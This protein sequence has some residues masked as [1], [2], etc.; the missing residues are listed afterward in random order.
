MLLFYRSLL[1]SSD[2]YFQ[3]HMDNFIENFDWYSIQQPVDLFPKFQSF[4]MF[5]LFDLFC[6]LKC[7][8]IIFAEKKTKERGF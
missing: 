3:I 5:F 7:S 6:V 2:I 4:A 8:E 1:A